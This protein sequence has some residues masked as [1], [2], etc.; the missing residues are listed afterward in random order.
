VSVRFSKGFIAE[1][2][3]VL[4]NELMPLVL[5]LKDINQMQ[6]TLMKRKLWL[7]QLADFGTVDILINN[8]GIGQPFNAYV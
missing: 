4:E 1:S 8:A 2:A 7:M 6:P 5:K 3:L